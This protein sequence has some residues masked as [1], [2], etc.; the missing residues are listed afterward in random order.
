[1]DNS[2]LQEFVTTTVLHNRITFGDVRRLQRDHLPGGI[3]SR[4][5]AEILIR[6]DAM[7]G[8]VDKAW[9]EWLTA[10]VFDFAVFS[11]R[12][13]DATDIGSL[14]WLKEFL[15]EFG[16]ATK[17]TKQLARDIHQVGEPLTPVELIEIT[18]PAAPEGC[19]ID[20]PLQL[21]IPFPAMPKSYRRPPAFVTS[22][23][24]RAANRMERVAA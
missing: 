15:A 14:A 3:T 10:A 23:S 8:Q 21:T 9:T 24:S 13:V 5:E 18:V 22:A 7:M 11:E 16:T 2:K 20:V 19:E 6:L 17:V 1:M 4:A 12:S